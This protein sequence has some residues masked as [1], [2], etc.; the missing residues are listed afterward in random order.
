MNRAERDKQ[1]ILSGLAI[2]LITAFVTAVL[3]MYYFSFL[4]YQAF[5]DFCGEFIQKYPDCR[6]MVFEILKL[7]RVSKTISQDENILAMFGYRPSDFLHIDR[8]IIVLAGA[9]FTAGFVLFLCFFL[10]RQ[11]KLSIRIQMLTHYLEKINTGAKGLIL[12]TSEDEFSS[13]Q[14]E[15]YKTVTTLYHTREE[16]LLAKNNFA[17]NLS[18]I[19]HQLKTPI[20]TIS[21]LSQMI[22]EPSSAK[23][24][25]Q[26]KQQTD[27]LTR[28]EEALLLLS[29]VDAGTLVMKRNPVDV[30]TLLT[31]AADNLS[32]LFLRANVSVD[33]PEMGE[34]E[35][36]AD[37]EWSMEA[38]MNLLKN[39]MEHTP[40]N[41]MV[42]CSYEKNPLY[43]QIQI[44]NEGEGFAKEDLP[45]LFE[46]FYRGK[47]ETGGGIG[48]GL[49]LAKAII[50]LQ[51]GV[52]RARNLPSKEA[53]FEIRFY[54]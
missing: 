50:E 31:L 9:G 10:Y 52:I 7:K 26:I 8:T 37:L 48:I 5:G 13:L 29:R 4:Q 53:C 20:T 27:R 49:S 17:E 34:V 3:L 23:S 47:N 45:H 42:H 15:I 21:L 11:K 14:D 41:G 35:I 40:E 44:W 12:E 38:V 25:R 19:A 51:N 46:R 30:F 2:S 36:D 6:Q 22:Q 1:M 16:A 32:E 39:C 33:I 54:K 43:V 18:N 28:L 24:V